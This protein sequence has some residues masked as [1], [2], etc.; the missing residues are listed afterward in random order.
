[1]RIKEKFAYF[2]QFLSLTTMISKDI[3]CNNVSASYKMFLCLYPQHDELDSR[4]QALEDPSKRQ[5]VN[6]TKKH[7]KIYVF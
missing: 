4:V 7:G 6:D 2:E 5:K 1:M 3:K